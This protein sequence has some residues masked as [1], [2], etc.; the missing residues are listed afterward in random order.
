[1]A[2]NHVEHVVLETPSA[3]LQGLFQSLVKACSAHL[4]T[5]IYGADVA[6]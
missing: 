3:G 2:H 1:M 6:G 4:T 5:V